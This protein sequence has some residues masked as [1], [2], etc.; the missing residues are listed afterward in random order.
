MKR[1]ISF[2]ATF[3]VAYVI[4]GFLSTFFLSVKFAADATVWDM[5]KT[6]FYMALKYGWIFKIILAGA[7]AIIVN[8]YIYGRNENFK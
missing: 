5:L 3:L 6:K 2:V 4:I 7:Y 8:Q 1:V